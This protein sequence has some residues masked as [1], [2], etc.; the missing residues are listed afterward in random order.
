LTASEALPVTALPED[1][2]RT[3]PHQAWVDADTVGS[4]LYVRARRPGDRFAPLGMD[5]HTMKLSDFMINVKIP[6]RARDRWPPP[7]PSLP[8]AASDPAGAAVGAASAYFFT[9]VT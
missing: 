8:G 4:P 2:S 5:G 3:P 9:R 7:G 1:M 6:R